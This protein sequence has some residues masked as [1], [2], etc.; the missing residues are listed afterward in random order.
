MRPAHDHEGRDEI[1]F[2]RI[3]GGVGPIVGEGHD[4]DASVD[5]VQKNGQRFSDFLSTET[6]QRFDEKK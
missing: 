4:I 6:I 3:V 5:N 2:L 1:D